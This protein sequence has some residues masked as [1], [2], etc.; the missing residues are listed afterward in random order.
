MTCL[1]W[2]QQ[3]VHC[4]I[5]RDSW[6]YEHDRRSA[7][8]AFLILNAWSRL[9]VDVSFNML[10]GFPS[11]SV[12]KNIC[13]MQQMQ[14]QFQGQEDSPGGGNGSSLQLSL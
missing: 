13:A 6:R 7:F 12:V 8:C 2:I 3:T 14:V 9:P 1:P 10:T 4:E 11:G 5:Q